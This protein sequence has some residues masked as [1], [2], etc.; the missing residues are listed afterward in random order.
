MTVS[1][2]RSAL[3][4]ATIS[5]GVVWSGCATTTAQTSPPRP[6]VSISEE[7]KIEPIRRLAV[8]VT[9]ASGELQSRGFG[10]LAPRRGGRSRGSVFPDSASSGPLR[11]VE[12]EF[13]RA[14]IERG[15]TL[16]ARSDLEA[17]LREQD[18]Q[19]GQITEDVLA[20]AGRVLNVDGVVLVT[21]N[22]V[23]VFEAKPMIYTEGQDYYAANVAISARMI[24]AQE[25]NV[26]WISSYT[27]SQR[28]SGRRTEDAGS[29]LTGVAYVVASGL[30]RVQSSGS[31]VEPQ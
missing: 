1:L 29:A 11:M 8:Y 21:I 30:P 28:I 23:D 14:A 10:G 5:A 31:A 15:Y 18:L 6:R 13:M 12:D 3:M 9:D 24:G 17:I 4:L 19:S 20:R 26:L 16:A 22:S 2:G 27:G 7:F 25:A